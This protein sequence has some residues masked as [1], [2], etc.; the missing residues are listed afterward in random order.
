MSASEIKT[1]EDFWKYLWSIIYKVL[2]FIRD[3]GKKPEIPVGT[4]SIDLDPVKPPVY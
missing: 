3:G 4:T 1:F 2:Q